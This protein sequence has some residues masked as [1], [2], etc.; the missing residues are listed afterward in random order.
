MNSEQF[1]SAKNL[2]NS[3][4]IDSMHFSDIVAVKELERANNLSVWSEVDYKNE[5]ERDNS[6]TLVAKF[7]SKAIGFLVAR[8]IINSTIVENFIEILNIES[9]KG[10]VEIYNI[11]VREDF[12]GYGIGKM[13][14]EKLFDVAKSQSVGTVWLDVRE[15]N[16][17]AIAFYIGQGFKVIYI[18][19]DFYNNPSENA[20]VMCLKLF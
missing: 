7:E 20:S 2:R 14:L 1:Q 8:L 15:S 6:V 13:L 19:K 4:K 17:N 5:I 18:R 9:K 16:N 3:V 12:R 10:E 11:A